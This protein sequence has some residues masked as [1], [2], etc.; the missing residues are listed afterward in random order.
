M[1]NIVYAAE[2]SSVV[3]RVNHSMKNIAHAVE[4]AESSSAE[5]ISHAI[6]N[7]SHA[8]EVANAVEEKAILDDK[9]HLG[10]FCNLTTRC[11]PSSDIY[12]H[13]KL[14]LRLAALFVIPAFG[15]QKVGFLGVFT[16]GNENY[17]W[18]K[19]QGARS[20]FID[21]LNTAE[22]LGKMEA[23]DVINNTHVRRADAYFRQVDVMSLESNLTLISWHSN[24][25]GFCA[26]DLDLEF[27][28]QFSDMILLLERTLPPGTTVLDS[29]KR[30]EKSSRGLSG[31][32]FIGSLFSIFPVLDSVARW[33]KETDYGHVK[34][35][36]MLIGTIISI[37]DGAN[38]LT[39]WS[40]CRLALHQ[41][42]RPSN[43]LA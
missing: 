25:W 34:C 23:S 32:L 4:I 41:G 28:F 13:R 16:F 17:P 20:G 33:K 24:I 7:I 27:C 3:E 39:Y 15:L 5:G 12:A 11:L 1:K 31:M 21:I 8:V 2:S 38:L 43:R 10:L 36:Q 37:I 22:Q 35:V 30:C 14:F 19:Y 40:T 9:C 6:K 26:Y 42:Y 29:I 18:L